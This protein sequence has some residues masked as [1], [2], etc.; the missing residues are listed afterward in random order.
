M[1][2]TG[3]S[4]GPARHCRIRTRMDLKCWIR[5][6]I[7]TNFGSET[8][9][10]GLANSL[11]TM[12]PYLTLFS[13]VRYREACRTRTTLPCRRTAGL[14]TPSSSS[15]SWSG[16]WPT[17]GLPNS[18]SLRAFFTSFWDFLADPGGFSFFRS[19]LTNYWV[20]ALTLVQLIFLV[21]LT[22]FFPFSFV[23][24]SQFFVPW[25]RGSALI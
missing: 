2:G 21:S 8:L 1:L 4:A 22:T 24:S 7:E 5:T 25:P 17:V 16:S 20:P 10:L 15:H 3:R 13:P 9:L 23:L 11:V 19:R 6:R 18:H 14:S 12:G